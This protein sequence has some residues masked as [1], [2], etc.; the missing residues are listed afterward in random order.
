MRANVELYEGFR[1][2]WERSPALLCFPVREKP[3]TSSLTGLM[4]ELTEHHPHTHTCSPQPSRLHTTALIMCSEI[5]DCN[6]LKQ[7]QGFLKRRQTPQG[8][9][10]PF[11]LWFRGQ[12]EMFLLSWCFCSAPAELTCKLQHRYYKGL[13]LCQNMLCFNLSFCQISSRSKWLW[14]RDQWGSFLL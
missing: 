2:P 9:L 4:D 11:R 14:D 12:T 1:D 6:L 7:H 10:Q 3:Q 5:P 13:L 8:I